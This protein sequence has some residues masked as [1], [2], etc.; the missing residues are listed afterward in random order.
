LA[1]SYDIPTGTG[2]IE[3]A[4]D[5]STYLAV[6]LVADATL[7]ANVTVKLQHSSDD[8]NYEDLTGASGTLVSGGDSIFSG[9]LVSGGDSILV[10]TYDYVLNDCFLYV[11]VGSA[12]TGTIDIFVSSKKKDDEIS[13]TIGGVIDTNV[14]N[15]EL[16]VNVTNAELDVDIDSNS[17]VINLL[18]NI[19]KEQKYTNKLL[20][21][22]LN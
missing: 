2:R 15:A 17:E 16:D 9:T 8:A 21:K 18:R 5:E 1:S 13:T 20:N 19:L 10:E 3:I 22:I 11:D 7:D 14:T 6:Q 12:T 4:S